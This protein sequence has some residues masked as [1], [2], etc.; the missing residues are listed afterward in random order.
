[1]SLR[2]LFKVVLLSAAFVSGLHAQAATSKAQ[3]KAELER[4]AVQFFLENTHPVTGLVRDRAEN[5]VQTPEWNRVASIAATG[6]G[7]AVLANAAKRGMVDPKKAEDLVVRALRF[8]RD[9]VGRHNGW[10]YHFIDWET[11]ARM[12]R[13]EFSTI[14]TALFMGGA[15]YA[16]EIFKHNSEIHQIT[17]QLYRDLD[18]FDY[19]TDGGTQPQK[20][21]I[22]MAYSVEDGYTPAQWDMYAEQKILLLLGLGHPTHP[23]P[24]EVW[25]NMNRKLTPLPNGTSVMGVEAAIFIHQYSLMFVDFRQ[26]QDGFTNYHDNAKWMSDWHRLIGQTDKRYKSLR[27]GFWGFSAG[28]APVGYRVW[29]ALNYQGI[30]CIGCTVASSV[31]DPNTYLEDFAKW[32]DSPYHKQLWGRYGFVDS[33][34]LDQNWFSSGVLGITVGPAYMSLANMEEKTS[35]WKDFMNIPEIKTAMTRAATAA[36]GMAMGHDETMPVAR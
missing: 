13:S 29:D 28:E 10:F 16:A 32:Y 3:I 12:W 36:Q 35:V 6:F 20:R 2:L 15:L 14:D 17:Y 5:F 4:T 19:M 24:A 21:T 18:F 27:E 8:S 7:M 31:Y 30:I 25:L 23:L 22:S 9:H 11:G 26:F 34:D 1:M 33:L